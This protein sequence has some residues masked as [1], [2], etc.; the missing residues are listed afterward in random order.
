MHRIHDEGQQELAV[1]GR[2]IENEMFE[3]EFDF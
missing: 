3:L 1:G 2:W